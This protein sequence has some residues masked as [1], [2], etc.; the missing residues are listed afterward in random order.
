MPRVEINETVTQATVGG[1]LRAVTGADVLV[2]DRDTG[3][4]ATVYAAETGGA[5]VDNPIL[6]VNGRIEGWLDLGEY[7]LEVTH[8][9]E[10]YS[11]PWDASPSAAI[12]ALQAQSGSVVIVRYDSD[13]EA[14]PARPDIENVIWIGP[15]QSDPPEFD[16]GSDLLLREDQAL[17]INDI[18]N[19]SETLGLLTGGIADEIADRAAGDSALASRMRVLARAAGGLTTAAAG[20]NKYHLCTSAS[21]STSMTLVSANFLNI[22][23]ITLKATDHSVAGKTTKLLVRGKVGATSDPATK[24]MFGLYATSYAAGSISLGAL[25]AGSEVEVTA[26]A[27]T[28]VPGE[29][30]E[31]TIPADGEYAL[32]YTVVPTGAN[33]T[34]TARM[35]ASL[36]I[37]NV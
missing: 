24:V 1:A 6:T 5:E 21:D 10:T 3:D 26:A 37:H 25:V 11:Q 32:G 33:P 19:L 18:A 7:T 4:P 20:G 36:L 31:F 34:Q 16:D 28:S 30:A 35:H 23:P 29:G 14:W 13:T 27:N 8:G 15:A 9:G 12:V 2:L 17:A 22:V